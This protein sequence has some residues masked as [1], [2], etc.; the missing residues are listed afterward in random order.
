MN[1]RNNYNNNNKRF[2]NMNNNNQNWNRK[3]VKP[4]DDLLT[5][6]ITNPSDLYLQPEINDLQRLNFS[7]NMS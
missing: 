1:N 7:F 3:K 5:I 6:E 2:N 4:N